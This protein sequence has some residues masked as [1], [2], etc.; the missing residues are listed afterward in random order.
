MNR[1]DNWPADRVEQFTHRVSELLTDPAKLGR[2]LADLGIDS[3]HHADQGCFIGRCPTCRTD[4]TLYIRYAD[5]ETSTFPVFWTCRNPE[6]KAE[7][8]HSSVL[9]L[10]REIHRRPLA[11]AADW[12]AKH[13]G[14]EDAEQIIAM[15]EAMPARDAVL[16]D[17]YAKIARPASRG[18]A[19]FY[20]H[21]NK[22]L[23]FDFTGLK[24]FKTL[25]LATAQNQ[26]VIDFFDS[27][28]NA[29][30]LS[31]E[32]KPVK[33]AVDPVPYKTIGT[34]WE[35]KV[36]ADGT[37]IR[38]NRHTRTWK[39]VETKANKGGFAYVEITF[40][41]K[42]VRYSVDRLVLEAF[43]GPAPAANMVPVHRDGQPGNNCLSNLEWGVKPKRDNKGERHGRSKLT[44]GDIIEMF[45]L[46]RSGK[47]N[48]EIAKLKGVTPSNVSNILSRKTWKHV[49]IP[50]EP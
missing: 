42:V 44:D 40:K 24:G 21:P 19:V 7:W 15:P 16:V 37:V 23:D 34:H 13:L 18:Y 27:L 31:Y 5:T 39:V 41:G 36:G 9:G 28:K 4:G 17:D 48:E 30:G 49:T 35:N 12:L 47:K 29:Y 46:H 33:I 14:Y 20:A 1:D 32:V 26:D 50:S 8:R 25:Y 3:R 45:Y 22:V 6:C 2:L 38:K 11:E 10:V 43:V